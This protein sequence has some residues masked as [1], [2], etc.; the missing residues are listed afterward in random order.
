[1][2]HRK[3]L[4]FDTSILQRT[5]AIS[6]SILCLILL[7]SGNYPSYNIQLFYAAMLLL[8]AV[9]SLIS[10]L[11][12]NRK[13]KLLQIIIMLISSL[14]LFYLAPRMYTGEVAILISMSITIYYFSEIYHILPFTYTLGFILAFAARYLVFYY[15]ALEQS[16]VIF[17]YIFF[18]YLAS[19]LFSV[20]YSLKGFTG[21]KDDDKHIADTEHK[22]ATSILGILHSTGNIASL[23]DYNKLIQENISD[24]K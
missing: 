24:K 10:G 5:L 23:K 1:M 20:I 12:I 7:V 21:K 17:G 16:N 11:F 22:I 8:F 3:S 18:V 19:I 9:V 4:I 15:N 6:G 2:K 14:I 13:T